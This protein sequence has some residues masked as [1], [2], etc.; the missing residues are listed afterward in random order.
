MDMIYVR[1]SCKGFVQ[2]RTTA[3]S[4]DNFPKISKALGDLPVGTPIHRRKLGPLACAVVS[5]CGGLTV[6][7][8]DH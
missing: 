5:K 1:L 8:A 7:S 6:A 3:A 4:N 2:A